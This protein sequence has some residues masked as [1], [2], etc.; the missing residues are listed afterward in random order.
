MVDLVCG[1]LRI[2]RKSVVVQQAKY[3]IHWII[4]SSLNYND[5]LTLILKMAAIR[6]NIHLWKIYKIIFYM[7]LMATYASSK[8][9]NLPCKDIWAN[10]LSSWFTFLSA[11]Q[12]CSPL[13]SSLLPPILYFFETSQHELQP[14]STPSTNLKICR[15][16][17]MSCNQQPIY[18]LPKVREPSAMYMTPQLHPFF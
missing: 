5:Q 6:T 1:T 3:I 17:L 13:H 10:P 12:S 18:W 2:K 4:S 15:R 8:S 9:F 16:A 11:I 14:A 7:L